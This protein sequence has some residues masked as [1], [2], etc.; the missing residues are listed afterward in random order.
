MSAFD[1]FYLFT[2]P[3]AGRGSENWWSCLGPLGPWLPGVPCLGPGASVGPS[4]RGWGVHGL[5]SRWRPRCCLP[6][7]L[8]LAAA[9]RPSRHVGQYLGGW[10]EGPWRVADAALSSR[11]PVLGPRRHVVLAGSVGLLVRSDE[12]LGGVA[13]ELAVLLR[14]LVTR[15]CRASA[16][17][18]CGPPSGRPAI[19]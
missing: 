18:R 14:G 7:P 10:A 9:G 17:E 2:A 15:G 1:I 6:A 3:G 12:C 16:G 5:R 13:C 19:G 11:C 4:P 8:A